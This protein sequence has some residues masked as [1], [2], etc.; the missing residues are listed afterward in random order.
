[1]APPTNN[2]HRLRS[3]KNKLQDKESPIQKEEET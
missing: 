2:M 3:L 1:M